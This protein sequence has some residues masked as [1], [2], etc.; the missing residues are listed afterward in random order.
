MTK[1]ELAQLAYEALRVA[2]APLP[3]DRQLVLWAMKMCQAELAKPEPGHVE[4]LAALVN[5]LCRQLNKVSPGND[6]AVKAAEYIHRNNLHGTSLRRD[7]EGVE[8]LIDM[9][10]QAKPEPMTFEEIRDG[11]ANAAEDWPH[12]D[13]YPPTIAEMIRKIGPTP[14]YRK[15]DV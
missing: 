15:E 6:V 14:I 7:E 11:I 2:S 4:N 12:N 13:Y 3:E 9:V 5:R 10:K 1:R 8:M